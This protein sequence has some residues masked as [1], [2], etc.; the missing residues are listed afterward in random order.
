MRLWYVLTVAGAAA[1]TALGSGGGIAAQT[2]SP[3]SLVETAYEQKRVPRMRTEIRMTIVDGGRQWQRT[4]T[5]EAKQGKTG[6]QV[7]RFT[8]R[9]PAD[10]A[11]SS[12]LTEEEGGG[13]PAQWVYIPAYHTVRRIAASQRGEAY[14]GTDYFYEDVLDRRWNDYAYKDLGRDTVDGV[15]VTRVEAAPASEEARRASPYSRTIYFVDPARKVVVREEYFDAAGKLLKR[16]TNATLGHYGRYQLWD[17]A[18]MENVQTGHQ[19]ISKVTKREVDVAIPDDTF[20]VRA[21]KRPR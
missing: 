15:S 7:Q 11:G 21:L 14:L 5:L 10:L 8:F 13:D 1:I 16:L 9:T 17:E 20:T 6:T 12:V 2:L 4:A 3:R 19:T 18:T